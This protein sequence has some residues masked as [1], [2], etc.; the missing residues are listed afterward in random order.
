MREN[1]RLPNRRQRKHGLVMRPGDM[2]RMVCN[3]TQNMRLKPVLGM[4]DNTSLGSHVEGRIYDHKWSIRFMR[5]RSHFQPP[6]VIE[7]E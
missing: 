4:M 2:E 5:A 1:A 7:V 3:A 6:K